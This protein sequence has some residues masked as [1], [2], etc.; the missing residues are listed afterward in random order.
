[1]NDKLMISFLLYNDLH[2]I[3]LEEFSFISITNLTIQAQ[4]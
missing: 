4:F 3:D 1:M 2:F